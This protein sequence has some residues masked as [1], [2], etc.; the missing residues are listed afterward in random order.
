MISPFAGVNLR[1]GRNRLSPFDRRSRPCEKSR[2]AGVETPWHDALTIKDAGETTRAR[3]APPRLHHKT[4][5]R[6]RIPV[7]AAR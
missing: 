7:R 6:P 4:A 5:K 1:G 3:A 2:D